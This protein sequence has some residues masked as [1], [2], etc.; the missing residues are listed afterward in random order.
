MTPEERRRLKDKELAHLREM[1]RLKRLARHIRR[2][3]RLNQ[4]LSSITAALDQVTGPNDDVLSTLEAEKARSQARLDLALEV[5]GVSLDA[6]GQPP[7]AA[8]QPEPDPP[9]KT[10]GANLRRPTEEPE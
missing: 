10:I 3:K 7:P 2:Q 1:Q 4:A 9:A 6:A 5:H 8:R